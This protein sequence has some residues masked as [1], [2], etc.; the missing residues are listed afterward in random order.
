[1]NRTRRSLMRSLICFA[2]TAG[3]TVALLAF[4]ASAAQAHPLGNFTINHY[5]GLTLFRDHIEVLA[6]V[7]R[8]EIP[9]L[10]TRDAVDTDHDGV[11]EPAELATAARTQCATLA[12]SIKLT[13]DGRTLP[14]ATL[15][16]G[17]ELQTGAAGLPTSRLSCTLTVSARLDRRSTVNLADTAD[18]DHVGWREITATGVGVHI[19]RSP[20]P[21]Q[22]ISAQL[23]HY[24]NDLL[25]AP[26]SV[27]SAALDVAPGDGPQTTAAFAVPTAGLADRALGTVTRTFDSLVGS[28]H[29]T[30]GVGVLALLLSLVLGASH[31]AL[32]GHGKTVMAAYLAGKRG[33]VRDAALVGATVTVTHTAGVLLLGLLVTMSETIAGESVL[34]WLGAVSGALIALIGISLL[35]N[36]RHDRD[37]HDHDHGADGH[38][39]PHHH[40]GRHHHDG[41][42]HHDHPRRSGHSR[43]TLMGMGLAGGL[44]PSPSALV[45][46]LGAIALGRTAFGI[47]LVLGYGVGMAAT[48]TAAGLLLVRLGRSGKR[49]LARKT[50]DSRVLA[51]APVATA[52]LILT[53]GVSLALRSLASLT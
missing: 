19:Q 20:V 53:V 38:A 51:F 16:N 15:R 35:R 22:S 34:A 18:A 25:S 31:A 30:L 47:A 29:L 48:L 36:A 10:Q 11:L 52:L 2:T 26:L 9:T 5:D 21:A 32:P 7:D 33:T 28:R 8:A 40:H 23:R 3:A 24:P 14:V 43:R 17:L 37:R 42:H 12:D 41:G 49:L 27:R 6:I 44:V 45:V 1:M 39:D 4:G 13:L 46:L 50:L